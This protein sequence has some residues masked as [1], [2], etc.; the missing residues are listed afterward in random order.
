[1]RPT[2]YHD[3]L[4]HP[5]L[6]GGL[7]ADEVHAPLSAEVSSVE[8]V[9]VLKLVPGLPPGQEVVMVADFAVRNTFKQDYN[10]KPVILIFINLY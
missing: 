9:P 8:P 4:E 2:C 7:E 3:L 10:S 6:S 5:K 1:M